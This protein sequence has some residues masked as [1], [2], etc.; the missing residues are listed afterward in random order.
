M[1]ALQQRHLTP[2]LVLA[3]L[4]LSALFICLVNG[5][6]RVPHW[7]APTRLRLDPFASEPPVPAAP[8]VISLASY[9]VVWQRPLFTPDRK[10]ASP[11]SA[12]APRLSLDSL[13]LTGIVLTGLLQVA[14]VRD[15]D[16][17]KD[18]RIR[19]HED[20]QGWTL[21]ALEPRRAV[22]CQAGESAELILAVATAKAAEASRALPPDQPQVLVATPAAVPQL[23]PAMPSASYTGGMP[24]SADANAAPTSKDDKAVRQAQLDALKAAVVRRRY[25][26]PATMRE[27]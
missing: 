16:N 21:A 24:P 9:V 6:G 15:R 23:G 17:S 22:F 2:I 12:N 11:V 26:S 4:L 14:L 3:C 20:Y 8:R 25:S 10:M 5:W 13:E 18:V 19:L 27:H 7:G 1:N